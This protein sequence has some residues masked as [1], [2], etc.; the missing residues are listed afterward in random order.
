MYS[1]NLKLNVPEI[2]GPISH[3]MNLFTQQMLY[4]IAKTAG[5]ISY[6]W[7]LE[8]NR[9]RLISACQLICFPL[10]TRLRRLIIFAGDLI[11]RKSFSYISVC[12]SLSYSTHINIC[13][14]YGIIYTHKYI[15][16]NLCTYLYVYIIRI[17]SVYLPK[18][19]FSSFG[20]P[21][22]NIIFLHAG[23]KRFHN[24]FRLKR[25]INPSVRPVHN[26]PIQLIECQR[27]Y[28][29]QIFAKSIFL[30]IYN[31]CTYV[32]PYYSHIKTHFYIIETGVVQ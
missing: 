9:E 14:R 32:Y 16:T 11:K 26:K 15:R 27:K 7:Q 5:N 31:G 12:I 17:I 4:C 8:R 23:W 24:I 1:K 2:S 10:N 25:N 20:T 3:C 30:C 28:F 19:H 6:T 29:G 18:K 22:F 13:M 21:S